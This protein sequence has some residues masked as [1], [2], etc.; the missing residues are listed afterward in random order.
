[1]DV[2]NTGR[3]NSGSAE[4]TITGRS[5]AGRQ[6]QRQPYHPA[7]SIAVMRRASNHPSARV[8]KRNF[9]FSS[10]R[11]QFKARVPTGASSK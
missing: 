10:A 1:M 2:I 9:A 5:L 4:Y 6:F 3:N 8:L 11:A 7:E